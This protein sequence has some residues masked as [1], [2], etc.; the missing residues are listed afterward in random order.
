MKSEASDDLGSRPSAADDVFRSMLR[1]AMRDEG[2]APDVLKGFQ[3]KVRERSGGKFYA[4]GWST[5]R[6]A[7]TNTYLITS[8]LMLVALGLIY[9]LL[10]PL[11]GE[12]ERVRNAPA[13]VNVVAPAPK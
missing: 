13:P 12:P 8:L 5:A 4:D 1:G 6:H 9:A 11:S 2:P 10:R 7:P 3:D